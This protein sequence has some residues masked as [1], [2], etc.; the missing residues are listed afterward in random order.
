MYTKNTITQLYYTY[1]IVNNYIA[2][3]GAVTIA[4]TQTIT[5]VKTFNN[6]TSFS[7]K[8]TLSGG[9]ENYGH[10]MI[11][12]NSIQYNVI[13]T[14]DCSNYIIHRSKEG[15]DLSYIQ[16]AQLRD[17]K[18]K[19]QFSASTYAS[20]GTRYT[21]SIYVTVDRSGNAITYAP[22]PTDGTSTTSNQIATVGWI[23]STGNNIVHLNE[24]ETITGTKTFSTYGTLRANTPILLKQNNANEGGQIDF[25]RADNSV[26]ASDPYI[27]LFT[28]TIRVVGVDSSNNTNIPLQVDIQNNTVTVTTPVSAANNSTKVATT[29]WVNSKM[30]VV[31][32]LPA[33][34]DPNVFYFIPE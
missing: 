16:L 32:A 29:A 31:S 21:A 2:S 8:V 3:G 24:M 25:Q 14:S 28:N 19:A 15:N 33:N 11:P 9:F 20:N 27:D 34:P 13:P 5:G 30:Q 26:L 17:G 22:T 18:A 4:D 23:N 10:L 7:G 6:H 1:E 12:N